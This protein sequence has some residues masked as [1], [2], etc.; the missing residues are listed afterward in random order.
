M[1]LEYSNGCGNAMID[2][3]AYTLKQV[4]WRSPSEHTIDGTRY[5][6][7]YFLG[8]FLSPLPSRFS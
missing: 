4:H 7:T 1:Q 2:G 3:K 5:A 6:R 8:F